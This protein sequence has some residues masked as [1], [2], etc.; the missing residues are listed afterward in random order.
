MMK[1][2]YIVITSF[3]ALRM[4]MMRSLLTILGIVIGIAAVTLVMSVSEGARDL[5]IGRFQDV[6]SRTIAIEPGREP[7][8]PTDFV[9]IFTDSLKDRELMA[10]LD[11]G[12]VP[13]LE[14]AYPQVVVPGAVS[15]EGE[16]FRGTNIGSSYLI[17]EI[18]DLKIEEGAF[19]DE[20]D[21]SQRAHVAV[22]GSNVRQELFGFSDSIGKTIKIK[23]RSFKIIGVLEKKGNVL[24]LNA[25]DLIIVPYSTAQE[26]LLGVNHYNG[27]IGR[28]VSEEVLDETVFNITATLRE[29][30]NITDPVK[31]DF[32]VN[33][34]EGAAETVG[35]I[36]GVLAALLSS[37]AAIS[38]VVGGIGIMNIMLVSV[39]ERTKEIG[40]RKAVGATNKDLLTQFLMEAVG[41]TVAG[42]VIGIFVGTTLSF[43]LSVV[44][45]RT[46]NLD[47]PFSFPIN[48]AALGF[49]V[50]AA[51]GL[52]FGLYPARKAARKSP[53]E[54]LRYE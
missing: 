14:F 35:T 17:Q 15:F 49:F 38:L 53:I 51:V 26:Y 34:Q 54:A 2:Q 8:G 6:G 20:S 48:A 40:L 7:Q 5:I 52:V 28:A 46:L 18:F 30:H 36:T 10:I 47:W 3:N 43:I 27:I 1:L 44:L 11:K 19:F 22:I 16:T 42:G 39:T 23:D 32:H 25:D 24:F 37:V 45:S 31:D 29:L 50:S 41:L 13:T 4:N 12:N 21:I 9:E 33:T